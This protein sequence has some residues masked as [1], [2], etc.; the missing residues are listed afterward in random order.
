MR[1]KAWRMSGEETVVKGNLNRW[2]WS[3]QQNAGSRGG[4]GVGN[5]GV[6]VGAVVECGVMEARMKN[7]GWKMEPL[8]LLSLRF[9]LFSLSF[10]SLFVILRASC[11]CSV[12]VFVA[13]VRGNV[14]LFAFLAQKPWLH[15]L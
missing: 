11:C 4:N 5:G 6:D 9:L 8:R 2:C 7:K 13:W 12:F 10:P 15:A 3:R 1:R 14:P